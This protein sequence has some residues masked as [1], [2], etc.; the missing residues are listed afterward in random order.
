LFALAL[1][2]LLVGQ[3]WLHY[4]AT[5]VADAGNPVDV[6]AQSELRLWKP[7]RPVVAKRGRLFL[8]E[9][10]YL[11]LAPAD[12]G[13]NNLRSAATAAFDQFVEGGASVHR[14]FQASWGRLGVAQL[15]IM[16]PNPGTR[17]IGGFLEAEVYVGLRIYWRDELNFKA[18]GQIGKIDY[19]TLGQKVASEWDALMPDARRM[20]MKEFQ[21]D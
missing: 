6:T 16:S 3:P 17:L 12:D 19:K 4:M 15:K 1:D 7:A 8:T 13:R 9:G 2:S 20:P 10:V 14:L 21:D 18:T 5:H 11:R